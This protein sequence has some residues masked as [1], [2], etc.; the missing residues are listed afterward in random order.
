GGH[1]RGKGARRGGGVEV[2][3]AALGAVDTGDVQAVAHQ[4]GGW[5]HRGCHGR[6]LRGHRRAPQKHRPVPS[7]R[8]TT[9]SADPRPWVAT[10]RSSPHPRSSWRAPKTFRGASTTTPRAWP[11][12]P[13][14]STTTPPRT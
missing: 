3:V 2:H 7:A 9:S 5:V 10:N 13:R 1:D 11:T 6:S 14:T 8:W 4:S 12:P